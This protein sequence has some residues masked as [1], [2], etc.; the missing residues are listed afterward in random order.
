MFTILL[1]D[2]LHVQASFAW[3]A[4]GR[5]RQGQAE[6]QHGALLS[7]GSSRTGLADSW[8]SDIGMREQGLRFRTEPSLGF[9]QHPSLRVSQGWAGHHPEVQLKALSRSARWIPSV[10]YRVRTLGGKA[11]SPDRRCSTERLGLLSV[12]GA[13]CEPGA[14]ALALWHWCPWA[15]A[16]LPSHLSKV[17]VGCQP[18]MKI[19]SS[20]R[21]VLFSSPAFPF[22]P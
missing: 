2:H 12:L 21:F 6:G 20:L 9:W 16:L 13:R 5:T 19:I 17:G 14:A 7:G 18:L 3:S 4:A 8:S 10:Q 22:S 15:R 1:C 11:A